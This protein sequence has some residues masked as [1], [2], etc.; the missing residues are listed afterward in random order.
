MYKII[1][2]F[3]SSLRKYKTFINTC[4]RF[5]RNGKL[6]V[7][8]INYVQRNGWQT[9]IFLVI[10]QNNSSW[11]SSTLVFRKRKLTGRVLYTRADGITLL[12]Y[13]YNIPGTLS[14]YR[15]AD[16]R[17]NYSHVPLSRVDGVHD[18]ARA[19]T[20]TATDN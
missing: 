19:T 7:A 16:T 20:C 15:C 8:R 11:T 17:R 5:D 4:L 18:A 2:I 9:N 13:V 12:I 1:H 14:V 3:K 10:Y 6:R